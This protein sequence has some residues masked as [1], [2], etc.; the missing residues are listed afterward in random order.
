MRLRGQIFLIL[1][2]FGLAPLVALVA[3]NF[4][5]ILDRLNDLESIYHDSYRRFFRAEFHDLNQHLFSRNEMVRLLAKVPEPGFLPERNLR[6]REA[7]N[8]PGRFFLPAMQMDPRMREASLRMARMRYTNWLNRILRDQKDIVQVLFLD[9]KGKEKFWLERNPETLAF[10]STKEPH[11]RPTQAFLEAGARLN[12]GRFLVSNISVNPKTTEADPRYVMILR[13]ISPITGYGGMANKGLLG[14][15]VISIDVSQLSKAFRDTYWVHSDGHYLSVD[16][17]DIGSRSAFDDFPGLRQIFGNAPDETS[18]DRKPEPEIW[19]GE[20]GRS[21]IWIPWFSTEQSGILWVGREVNSSPVA[22]ILSAFP[23]RVIAIVLA[24]IAV[25]LFVANWFARRAERLGYELTDGIRR[26]VAHG[27]PVRFLWQRPQD[28]REFGENLTKLTEINARHAEALKAHSK[29]LEESNRYKSEFLANVSHELRTPLN[30]IILLS[31]ML[32]ENGDNRLSADH[33][34]Q[35]RVIHTAAQDL[36]NLIDDIL[37]LS[38]ID[39]KQAILTAESI[40]LSVLC[41]GL[42]ELV[43]PQIKEKRLELR[44]A[45]EEG[46]PGSLISD[47]EKV[48]Q[49]LKNFLSNAIK[50][51]QE[52]GRITMRVGHNSFEDASQR[53]LGISVEDTGIGIP[54]EKL[55]VV[56]E[57]FQQADGSTSRRY[58]G[59]GL[60]LTI[61]RELAELLGGRIHLASE[62]GRGSTFSLL[63]PTTW[64]SNDEPT[65]RGQIVAG[66]TPLL[67]DDSRDGPME[68]V[69]DQTPPNEDFGGKKI[70]IV[71]DDIHA[72]LALAPQLDRWGLVV[73]AAFDAEEASDTLAEDGPFDLILISVDLPEKDGFETI[74]QIRD[75]GLFQE[76]PIVALTAEDTQEARERC[77]AAGAVD[78]IVKPVQPL[79]LQ[80][81]LAGRLISADDVADDVVVDGESFSGG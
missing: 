31:K 43:E 27:E 9:K 35:S 53:P 65:A 45:F 61:S 39:A 72:L 17:G 49:I 57:A 68:Y 13:L 41:A 7:P 20:D 10:L 16:G 58:G 73:A 14:V 19:E 80:R 8:A 69:Q 11:D 77:L 40:D 29:E 63:L 33:V 36:R 3:I 52:G 4:P 15:V 5:V 55:E 75:R 42:V 56:F 12:P 44:V 25:V 48:R 76:I 81:V 47:N 54:P 32:A 70:L 34:K 1:L 30:S 64:Q 18:G 21:V 78:C 38:R 23:I 2:L 46:L 66:T 51:T 74:F 60:G 67:P 6:M 26:V 59:T 22:D 62:V 79:H 24:L 50:F 37:D 28:L 71:D